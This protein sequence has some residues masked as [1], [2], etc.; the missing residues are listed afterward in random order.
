M[1]YIDKLFNQHPFIYKI[2]G[3]YYAFG[4]MVCA[5]CKINIPTLELRYDRYCKAF[6]EPVSQYGA[7]DIFRKLKFAAELVKS[8]EGECIKPKE[9]IN[10]FGFSDL[11]MKEL[12]TQVNKYVEFWQKYKLYEFPWT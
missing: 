9:E 12:E 2:S 8:N 3:K 6:S 4:S 11:E 7:N 1:S 5:E 10:K